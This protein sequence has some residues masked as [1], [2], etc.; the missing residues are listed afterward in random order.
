MRIG[1]GVERFELSDAQA[2]LLRN[3]AICVARTHDPVRREVVDS[4]PGGFHRVQMCPRAT[5]GANGHND[6]GGQHDRE[7]SGSEVA[8]SAASWLGGCRELHGRWA[9]PQRISRCMSNCDASRRGSPASAL[10]AA[11]SPTRSRS[12]STADRRRLSR[13]AFA[14]GSRLGAA[15][16][17]AFLRWLALAGWLC[18]RMSLQ[19]VERHEARALWPIVARSRQAPRLDESGGAPGAMELR[20]RSIAP[21][22]N[23]WRPT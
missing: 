10:F 7:R 23:M 8:R 2:G 4:R 19:V 18:C 3:L 1:A 20:Q 14:V 16:C 15:A 12:R 17:A 5:A 21:A 11:A 13:R 9:S 22:T 6:D